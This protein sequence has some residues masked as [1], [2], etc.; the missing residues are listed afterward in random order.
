MLKH[1]VKQN[2]KK[3]EDFEKQ[4]EEFKI[5]RTALVCPIREKNEI[6]TIPFDA[7]KQIK[8]RDDDYKPVISKLN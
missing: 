1:E 4:L 6:K 2:N 8:S 5:D 7:L 3:F